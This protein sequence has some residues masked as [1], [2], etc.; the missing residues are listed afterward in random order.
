MD[1][2]TFSLWLQE[3]ESVDYWG[4]TFRAIY[5]S[6]AQGEFLERLEARIEEHDAEIE[7]MCNHH[8][9][10]FIA[11]VRELLHVREDAAALNADVVAV[12][13][14]ARDSA[15]SVA[16][17]GHDLVRA[18]R[19][20]KNMAATIESL[21]VCL[22]VLQ[23][24]TKLSRQMGERR[25]HPALKTLEQLEHT[26]LPRIANYRFSKHMRE[27]VPRLRESIKDASMRELND[28]LEEVRQ[29]SPKIGEA[30]MRRAAARLK[31]DPALLGEVDP[32]KGSQGGEDEEEDL[33]AEDLVDFSP[34]YKCL[35]I[36]SV[37]GMHGLYIGRNYLFLVR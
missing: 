3:V 8:Y 7:K 22:P 21:S 10:G 33:S 4:P 27:T 32:T 2:S 6:G 28:F 19:V 23:T 5:E 29:T 9:Q 13:R 14:A 31:V 35:H 25:Y 1:E 24:F 16:A 12:D 37:L 26:H 30:A 20:E 15:S 36:Y 18:R 34:V 11:S 17:R